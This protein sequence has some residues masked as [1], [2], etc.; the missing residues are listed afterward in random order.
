MNIATQIR[1]F[2][3]KDIAFVRDSFYKAAASA[4]DFKGMSHDISKPGFRKRFERF[5]KV[6]E[7]W[8][9][10]QEEH[11]EPLLGWIAVTN[12]KSHSIVWW[13]YVK[14]GYRNLGFAK[15]ML[16]KVEHK[17]SIVY[18]FTS[19]ISDKI[20]LSVGATYNPFVYEDMCFEDKKSLQL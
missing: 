9:I 1:S 14:N 13:V 4:H 8:I 19:R 6:S 2:K 16:A 20:S 10:K 3:D 15:S 7:I 5:Q 17:D 11:E 12:L 18:P